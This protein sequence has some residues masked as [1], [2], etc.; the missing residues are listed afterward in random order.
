[1]TSSR[2]RFSTAQGRIIIAGTGRAGTT[3]LVQLFTALGFGTGFSLAQAM[4]EVDA[5][6]NAGLEKDLVDDTNPYV[7]KSPWFADDLAAALREKR[8][9]I[10]AALLPMRDL[11]SA[12]ESRRRVYREAEQRGFDP[13]THPGSLWH[14]EQQRNQ[15]DV[16]AEKFYKTI[17]PLIE[18]GV[19]LYPLEFP[20]LARDRDYL[21]TKL[22]PLLG[23]HGV[24]HA[25]FVAAY[26]RVA[27]PDL[28]HDFPNH[29]GKELHTTEE[30]LARATLAA[31]KTELREAREQAQTSRLESEQSQRDAADLRAEITSLQSQFEDQRAETQRLAAAGESLRIENA[32][33]NVRVQQ[34]AQAHNSLLAEVHLLWNSSSWRLFRPLR[35]L[36]RRK[37]GYS[38]EV[39]PKPVSTSEALA[40]V[41]TIRDSLSWEL[42]APLRL[43]HRVFRLSRPAP[44]VVA[45]PFEDLT[46]PSLK[47]SPK[48]KQDRQ[49]PLPGY[50]TVHP[51]LEGKDL[52]PLDVSVSVIIPTYNAGPEFYWLL[53]KL[54]A[55]TGL[56]EVEVVVVDSGS[57]DGTGSLGVEMGCKVVSI[58]KSQFT[59]SYA[60][61]LGAQNASGDFL[62]FMVQDAFP[63]GDSWLYGLV[64]CLL[65][66]ESSS[67]PLAA[68]SCAEYPRTDTELL[69]NALIDTHHKFLGCREADRVGHFTGEDNLSLRTQGQLSSVACLIPRRRFEQYQYQGDYA[70]DLLLGTRLIRDGH[71]V[72]FLSSIK[73]VHSHN[74]PQG[75]YIR[76]VFVDVLFL[77][78]I[79]PD[80]AIPPTNSPIAILATAFALRDATRDIEPS[81]TISPSDALSIRIA[82]LSAVNPPTL[83]GDFSRRG[84][85]GY[86][87]LGAWIDRIATCV[88]ATK[89]ALTGKIDGLHLKNTFIDRLNALKTYVA[90]TYPVLDETVAFQ[91]NEAINKT[92]AMSIGAQLAFLYLT[93]ITFTA[94]EV[95]EL[96]PELK[97]ILSAG[98]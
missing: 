2:D 55:Q 58:D 34:Q 70:E 89:R 11:F 92:L 71:K 66:S 51:Q 4:H 26:D 12:A 81:T 84:D 27:R 30:T 49:F 18:F 43:I 39:E 41:L 62:L 77:T 46:R 35:N 87:P 38:D 90:A 59:H 88:G 75:Y 13:I 98:I 60:R 50:L 45:V 42:S 95:G 97:A 86:P 33:L 22:Q 68:L 79:F 85:F 52:V 36:I 80:F 6:S 40:T 65:K 63:V 14:T 93:S 82:E 7:I 16:L 67:E 24:G 76:R 3:F 25:E 78:K 48:R 20:R 28:I 10:Y 83:I 57:T 9:S 5:I 56:R 23:E 31:R 72:G 29:R 96:I 15:E 91:L 73:V 19:P 17:F 69:Y 21:F 64:S 94:D 44:S 61:N 53:R 32:M 74:R 37:R 1:M 54:H 8:I 47:A